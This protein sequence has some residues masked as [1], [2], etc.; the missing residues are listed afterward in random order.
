MNK[1]WEFYGEN[2]E[3]IID[4]AKKHNISE[5]LTK[6]LVNRGITDDKEIDTFLNPTRNDFYDPYLMPDMDK[7]V[8]RIIK[9]I[10][11]QEKVMIYGDY[12]VDGITSITVLKKF[13]EERGLKTG[14]YI[15]N[16]LEEG[17]GLNE[18][19][20]RS[21]AEQ[22]YTL[23]ITVD[24][25]ISGIEEVELANQLGIETI[26]TDHHEQSESL[27]NAYA[28]INAKRK[29]SQY[30]FR[31]LAGCGAVFKLIQAISLR[32][33]LEE[34]EFLKYLDI[35]C[36]G[37]ISDI[38]PLVDENRV[39][40]KLGLKLVAQTRNI[41]LR[42][43]ILQSGY[44]KIDSNT[45]SFGVAPRINACGRMGYQEE[46]LDLFLTNNIEEV[47]KITARLNSYNLERQTKEKDIFEQAI[48]E[49]E[50]E[51][52]EKLNTIVLSGDNWHHGVIG[53]VASKLTEK[54]YKPTILICFEDNIGKGSG[55]SLPG[56]DLHEALVETSAYLEKYGGH[57]MAVGL[58]LKKEKYNDFK[59]A[60][61]E[62]A[63][64]KNI[65]Q[66]IPVI[67]IDSI[68]TAKDVN[69]KTIQD[70]EMLEP[71]GEKNKNPIFVYKNLKIDSIRALSEGKHLKLTLKDDNLLINAIGF[72]LGYLSEEYLIGDKIDIAGNLEI[73]KYGRR[74]DNPNKYKRCY[75]INIEK[76]N[77]Y[78]KQRKCNNR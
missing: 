12:D 2:S 78:A 58:S 42:E 29:D 59:L 77:L 30:P 74:R 8:E 16:R 25:G 26:I 14:H 56:F 1:K 53:I 38:V 46:A 47:R 62:I 49:L 40:A 43:L 44:K 18:N 36:V 20:I 9:A 68:I 11:N 39:I 19:A 33:G 4:I 70:L 22:K 69:K 60:F 34:K 64:S 21:I 45:I 65:Q 13:L 41:G 57:E 5:L 15:P 50:K 61:E 71:F 72:N 54:F 28:I 63:K 51:D 17:Y 10:N 24:C 31:G 7:A 52:I 55:R 67:K 3:E 37:T 66:I 76:G 35:V 23:M 6:I 27:P 73:N 75:E 48:K 32:L